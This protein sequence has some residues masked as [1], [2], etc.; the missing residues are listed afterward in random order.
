VLRLTGAH[1][2]EYQFGDKATV[3]C[4]IEVDF[5]DFNLLA[6]GRITPEEVMVRTAIAGDKATALWFLNNLE[7]PY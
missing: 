3:D 1:A 5:F 2:T 6:S 7:V 4:E